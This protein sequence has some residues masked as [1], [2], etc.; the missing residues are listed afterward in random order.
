MLLYKLKALYFK[1]TVNYQYV[2]CSR[3]SQLSIP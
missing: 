3:L 2:L 1:F